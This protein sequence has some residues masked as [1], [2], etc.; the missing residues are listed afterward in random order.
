MLQLISL[1]S[2]SHFAFA[3]PQMNV[4]SNS[5]PKL[6]KKFYKLATIENQ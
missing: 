5:G 2:K 1:V 6:L 3:N 4:N